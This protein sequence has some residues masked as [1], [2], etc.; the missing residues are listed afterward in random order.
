MI[1]KIKKPAGNTTNE[2]K[3]KNSIIPLILKLKATGYHI[4]ILI[5]YM[6]ARFHKK[7]TASRRQKQHSSQNNC[8]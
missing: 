7:H 5:I 2:K 4:S 3:E 6:P 1:S 8:R